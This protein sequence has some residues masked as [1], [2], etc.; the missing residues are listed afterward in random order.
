L[1]ID[2]GGAGN[3]GIAMAK[4]TVTSRGQVTLRK[5][6]LNHLDI[7]PGEKIELTLLPLGRAE[8]KAAKPA[9]EIEA[10]CGFLADKTTKI[11]T[12]EEIDEAAASGW[13]GER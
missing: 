4:L 5:D 13:A 12:L 8:L 9:G 11:A 1:D 7:N 6:V 3:G 10:F 2:N